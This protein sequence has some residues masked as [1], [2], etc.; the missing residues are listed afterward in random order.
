MESHL[1]IVFRDGPTGRRA[2]V[3]NGPDVWEIIPVIKNEDAEGVDP[4]VAAAEYFGLP[5]HAIR[6]AVRYY[7]ECPDEIDDRIRRNRELADRA[8][9]QWRR[10]QGLPGH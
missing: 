1:G 4:I 2:A 7:A 6:A 9:A 3:A 10:E 5:P 8:E